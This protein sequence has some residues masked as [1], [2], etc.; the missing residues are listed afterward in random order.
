M[1]RSPLA[2]S[3]FAFAFAAAARFAGAAE[4]PLPLAPTHPLPKKAVRPEVA[5]QISTDTS[6][7]LTAAAPKFAGATAVEEPEPLVVAPGTD[8]R[9]IDKP[10]NQI[11]RLP[12]QM[13]PPY[14][15][16]ENRLPKLKERDVLTFKGRQELAF[17][18]RPGLKFLSLPIPPLNNVGIAL[19]MLEEDF[20]AERRREE[21]D[22]WGL[23]NISDGPGSGVRVKDKLPNRPREWIDF[24]G[25]FQVSRQR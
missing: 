14:I 20:A 16:E 6:A 3:L 8:L 21:A 9:E 4:L 22:L 10:R 15:V 13:L 23:Y 18:R 2:V 17:K 12:A 19:F 5:H 25:P 1:R 24:G 11:L 7:K